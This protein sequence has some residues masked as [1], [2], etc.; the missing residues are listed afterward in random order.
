MAR[1]RVLTV[2]AM[3]YDLDHRDLHEWRKI[4]A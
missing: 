3:V 1:E 2:L 4:A